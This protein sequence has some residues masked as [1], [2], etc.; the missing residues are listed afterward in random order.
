MARVT[1]ARQGIGSTGRCE[2]AKHKELEGL[3][4]LRGICATAVVVDHT[5]GML[6]DP[7]YGGFN[8]LGGALEYGFLGVDIFFVIS[9]FIMCAVVLRGSD[10][11]PK[12]S[13]ASFFEKRFSRIVPLMWIA[14]LSYAAMQAVFVRAPAEWGGYL[15]AMVLWPDSFLRPTIIWTLRQELVFYILF[16]LAF[17]T[18]RPA[19]WILLLWVLSPFAYVATLGSWTAT[20]GYIDTTASILFSSTN[21]EFGA[22]LIV[23]LLFVRFPPKRDLVMPV[24]PLFILTALSIAAFAVCGMLG[25][26]GQT[27]ITTGL[28]GVMGGLIVA[29]SVRV[30]CPPG[31][32]TRIGILLGN[33][34]YSIYLFH[35]HVLAS[36]LA[37]RAKLGFDPGG[38]VILAGVSLL[39]IGVGVVISL[40][41]EQP[42]V[43]LAKSLL[44]RPNR[45]APAGLPR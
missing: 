27:L 43:R 4:M 35:S 41:I 13:A 11:T 10:F 29:L 7:K 19:R 40:V 12:I 38:W 28:M 34:S 32:V 23:G 37:V 18:I 24:N 3:Q 17:F 39:A 6:G 15:R 45:T 33:A 36:V 42:L 9:A 25:L 21:L 5:A 14:I 26:Q 1:R 2:V 30:A 20:T 16:C 8:L 31:L 22:G 44:V